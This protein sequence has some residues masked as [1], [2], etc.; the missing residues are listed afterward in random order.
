MVKFLSSEIIPVCNYINL[1]N[2]SNVIICYLGRDAQLKVSNKTNIVNNNNNNN[3][4]SNNNNNSNNSNINNNNNNI[5]KNPL[6]SSSELPRPSL[7]LSRSNSGDM[8]YAPT[9]PLSSESNCSVITT[10][11]TTTPTST[12]GALRQSSFQVS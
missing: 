2:H 12:N 1:F 11:T 4:S 5:N 7:K 8:A 3:N 9:N 10:T 6:H